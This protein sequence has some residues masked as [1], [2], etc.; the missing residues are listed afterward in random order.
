MKTDYYEILGLQRGASDAD[1]KKAY[2]KIAKKYHPDMNPGDKEAEEKFKEAAEANEVL[3]DPEKRK[4]YD[5]YGH[6]WENAKN[7]REAF[8][9]GA[10]SMR[11]IFEQMQRERQR[12]QMKGSP[13][14]VKVDLTL[15]ECFNG[16]NKTVQYPYQKI[17][18]GC[19]GNGAKNGT[20]VHTCSTCGGSGKQT[21]VIQRGMHIMQHVTTCGSCRG[22]GQVIDEVCDVCSGNGI[23]IGH[24]S[25][26]VRFP[27]GVETGQTLAKKGL[28]HESRF[29]GGERG[30]AVFEINEIPHDLFERMDKGLVY[31]HKI[32]FEDLAL[33]TQIEVQTISGKSTRI[34]VEPN[35]K[36]GKLYRLKGYGMPALNLSS[37]MKPGP[38][39]PE[40]AFGDYVVELE[41]DIP[42]DFSEEEINLIKQMRELKNKKLEESK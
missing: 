22:A 33:G 20:S 32:S 28:G 15:E 4:W 26:G 10:G 16:C 19:K 39:V 2:R 40:S 30:D 27:R 18:T 41:I 38:G 7:H 25:V 23:E 13:I 6:D 29:P 3:S 42:E 9:G 34:K 17:C 14:H 1:I 24:E 5:D 12:E 36:N 11:D 37:S 21:H 35:T 8:S 31:R